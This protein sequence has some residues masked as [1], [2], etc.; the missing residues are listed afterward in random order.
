MWQAVRDKDWK[1]FEA[2]L[3]PMFVGVTSRGVALDRGGWLAYWKELQIGAYTFGEVTVK[4]AGAD[5][6]VTYPLQLA[7][8]GGTAPGPAL[9]VVS[10]WQSVKSRWILIST[11]LT[12]V[13]Q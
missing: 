6:V 2:H 13:V 8:P 12:P 9:R 4:P 5:M 3:A 10:V 7:E 11:S 1:N